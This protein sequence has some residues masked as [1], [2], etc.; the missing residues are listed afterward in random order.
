[1]LFAALFMVG[2]GCRSPLVSRPAVVDIVIFDQLVNREVVFESRREA[3]RYGE[4]AMDR[5][6]RKRSY[7]FSLRG[8]ENLVENRH[9]SLVSIDVSVVD[10]D[11]EARTSRLRESATAGPNGAFS[12]AEVLTPDRRFAIRVVHGVLLPES[13]MIDALDPVSIAERIARKYME[14]KET[15]SGGS[16]SRSRP[17]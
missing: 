9:F 5:T 12:E 6:S 3:A 7:L 4:T 2:F 8:N 15:R 17:I 10:G 13:V 1:M 11:E 14:T 16:G